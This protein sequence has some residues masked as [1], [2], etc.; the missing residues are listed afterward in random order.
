MRIKKFVPIVGLGAVSLF[1]SSAMGGDNGTYWASN[2]TSDEKAGY[3]LDV[4]K[5]GTVQATKCEDW[6]TAQ[7]WIWNGGGDGNGK[8]PGNLQNGNTK[9]HPNS[10]LDMYSSTGVKINPCQRSDQGSYEAQGW[11]WPAAGDRGTIQNKYTG[12]EEAKDQ[13]NCLQVKQDK[14]D[15]YQVTGAPCNTDDNAQNWVWITKQDVQKGNW[16]KTA[17]SMKATSVQAKPDEAEA[18][19]IVQLMINGKPVT[20]SPQATKKTTSHWLTPKNPD[21][22]FHKMGSNSERMLRELEIACP[23]KGTLYIEG[24]AFV[25]NPSIHTFEVS[26]SIKTTASDVISTNDYRVGQGNRFTGVVVAEYE[27]AADKQNQV[28][29]FT[30]IPS[31]H[32][33]AANTSLSITYFS[34]GE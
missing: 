13:Q 6:K 8:Y 17:P 15:V 1:S 34:T 11:N 3:C 30:A 24:R 9:D 29:T 23:G 14:G 4:A 18:A 25:I 20:L 21:G 22:D 16:C 31:K 7:Q 5:D 28:I 32:C 12:W 10:C 19:P 27:C 2:C 26:L 33:E